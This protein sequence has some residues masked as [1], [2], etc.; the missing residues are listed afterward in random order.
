MME[1]EKGKY[2]ITGATG[3][4]GSAIV[5]RLLKEGSLNVDCPVRDMARVEDMF[6]SDSRAKV[7]WIE[8]PLEVFLRNIPGQYDYI[9]HCACPTSSSYF[10]EH[11]V[12][13]ISFSVSTITSLLDYAKVHG[14]KS[15]VF[16]SSLEVYGC[17]SD[18][19]VVVNEDCQGYVNPLA[20]RSS[21]NMAKRICESLCAAYHAEYMLPV[22]IVRLTQTIP[23]FVRE[24]DMRLYAQFVRHAA[25]GEDIVLHTDGFSARPYIGMED[26][27]EAILYVLY[28]G[29]PGEA[30]NAANEDTY[31][32]VRDL[33][34]FIQKDSILLGK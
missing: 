13:T 5:G 29:N 24:N 28:H 4:I 8:A 2:L 9:I 32:S 30:Y 25:K 12:D 15:I 3:M 34:K 27:V 17:I 31:I 21:Y 20:P 18:D 1:L 7:H 26:A 10:V 16:L 19:S 23:S 22:K 14:V 33:A 11:P 6:D